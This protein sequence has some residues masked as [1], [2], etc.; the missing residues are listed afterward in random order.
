[1]S[2]ARLVGE[3]KGY[4]WADST[5]ELYSMEELISKINELYHDLR[6]ILD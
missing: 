2:Y 6:A 5:E 3:N 1:M 4:T